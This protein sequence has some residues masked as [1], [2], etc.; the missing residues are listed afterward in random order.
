M[1]LRSQ[2]QTSGTRQLKSSGLNSLGLIG[3]SITPE[4]IMRFDI[5]TVTFDPGTLIHIFSTQALSSKCLQLAASYSAWR[6]NF[7]ILRSP[8]GFKIIVTWLILTSR[9][10]NSRKVQV[11]APLGHSLIYVQF[12]KC[13]HT[14]S[15]CKDICLYPFLSEWLAAESSFD[16]RITNRSMLQASAYIVTIITVYII[17]WHW[18]GLLCAD[19]PL[20]NCSLTVYSCSC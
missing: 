6:N 10:Q 18:N 2:Q 8:S 13:Q 4:V 20:R 12:L 15:E 17:S 9:L 5:L 3:I 7:R 19:V 1:H 11:C 14:F 16:L